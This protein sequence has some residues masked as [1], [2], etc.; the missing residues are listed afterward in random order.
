MGKGV[1]VV[2]KRHS[3]SKNP[4]IGKGVKEVID[5]LEGKGML[6]IWPENIGPKEIIRNEPDIIPD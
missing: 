5:M 1:L 4:A 3:K 2:L 6:L